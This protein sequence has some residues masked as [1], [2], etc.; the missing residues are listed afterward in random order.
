MMMMMMMMTIMWRHVLATEA[1]LESVP[2]SLT[3]EEV[4]LRSPPSD[5]SEMKQ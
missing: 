1:E 4:S 2:F 3:S 5:I